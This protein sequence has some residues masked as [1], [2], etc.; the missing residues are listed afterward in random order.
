MTLASKLLAAKNIPIAII[1]AAIPGD[2][3]QQLTKDAPWLN[4]SPNYWWQPYNDMMGRLKA[5]NLQSSV[6]SFFWWQG[7]ANAFPPYITNFNE[8]YWY[9][10]KLMADFKVDCNNTDF[11]TYII[12]VRACGDAETNLPKIQEAQR[13]ISYY[14]N[15]TIITSNG[16]QQLT[17]NCHY[18]FKYGYERVAEHLMPFLFK[19]LN[20]TANW[21]TQHLQP[22][23]A[24][25]INNNQLI[26]SMPVGAQL[27][28]DNGVASKFR[29]ED[30]NGNPLFKASD[31]SVINTTLSASD[32]TPTQGLL[33][34][35]G[36]SLA[37]AKGITY[38]SQFVNVNPEVWNS[39]SSTALLS[40]WNKPI[41]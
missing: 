39:V 23:T 35:F 17:D 27:W 33:V 31:V 4:P 2:A 15:Y 37:N 10:N 14:N 18:P 26:I 24:R 11:K 9:L 5:Y 22:W 19:D 25:K 8:Y 6:T 34:T 3:I 20:Y 12:Q 32:L 7:E 28:A 16:L 21:P 1:N 36:N 13:L 38:L 41:E 40:F 30:V 29:V